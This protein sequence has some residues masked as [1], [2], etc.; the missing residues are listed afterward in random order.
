MVKTL[1]VKK[2]SPKK[3]S[4]FKTILANAQAHS[5]PIV[6]IM[7]TDIFRCYFILNETSSTI[8]TFSVITIKN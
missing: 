3:K 5:K 2:Y 6:K 1:I 7:F 8:Q 4:H